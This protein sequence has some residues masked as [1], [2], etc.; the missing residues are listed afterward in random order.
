MD[1]NSNLYVTDHINH[2]IRMLTSIN[3]VYVVST[4]AGLAGVTG[5]TDGIVSSARFYDPI[6][7][8][9]SSRGIIYI[10]GY[11]D[12]KIRAIIAAT[13]RSTAHTR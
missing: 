1:S 12:N 9:A 5:I 4:L 11:L 3:G 6:G 7:I 10:G 13:G 8:T 2:V